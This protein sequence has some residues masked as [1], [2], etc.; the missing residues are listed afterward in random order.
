MFQPGFQRANIKDL[1]TYAFL[2]ENVG[3]RAFASLCQGI[4]FEVAAA[5][6]AFL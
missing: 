5:R 3:S 2:V 1:V 4:V 6:L